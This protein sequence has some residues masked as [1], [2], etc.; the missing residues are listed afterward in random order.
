MWFRIVLACILVNLG[1]AA[2]AD[3]PY[4]T[5]RDSFVF[6][7]DFPLDTNQKLVQELVALRSELYDKL[8]LEP[9]RE[10]IDVY[11]FGDK[12][13]YELYMKRYFPSVTPRR[14]MFI[15]SNSPGN[16]FAYISP[17]FD[18]DL[19]HESTHSLLHAT[20]PMVPLWLDEG[21]AEYFEM[22]AS[23]RQFG[24]SYLRQVQRAVA[25][26]RPPSMERLESLTKLKEMGPEEYRQSWSWVHFMLHGPIEAQT[27][28]ADYLAS[29]SRHEPPKMPLSESLRIAIPDVERA[30][31]SHFRRQHPSTATN[32]SDARDFKQ[33]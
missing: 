28:L 29:I 3:W 2:S 23:K 12:S 32:A 26:R 20:L 14:A 30:F 31:K 11:L 16:V 21:L 24:H 13:V 19:R 27:V 33:R 1:S 17:Q 5:S 7:A 9:N 8:K 18:V 15:K 10:R 6:H 4:I 22:E 25:W